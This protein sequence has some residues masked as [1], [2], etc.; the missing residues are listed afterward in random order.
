MWVWVNS[1]SWW[2]TERPGVLRFMGS[3]RVGHDWAELRWYYSEKVMA[4]H[5]ST[6]AWKSHGWRSL[7]GC[8]PWGREESDMTEWLHFHFSLSCIGEG[9]DN[10]L[11]CSCLEDPRD[12]GAWWAAFY[13]VAQSRTLLKWLSSSSSW[14][15][16]WAYLIAQLVKNLPAMREIWVRSLGWEDPLEKGTA[17][18]SSI[19]ARRIPWTVWAWKA[20]RV[21]EV[22]G[23]K[24]GGKRVN[25]RNKKKKWTENKYE[26]NWKT[27]NKI[28]INT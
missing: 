27:R 7:V 28:A 5:S 16:Y 8:S 13:G 14:W 2:W 6:L 1:G 10:P 24:P 11:Q 3:H 12:G 15:Y 9:N 26:K 23:Q 18:H 4:P 22:P 19:L 20:C 17:T 25:R 21:R